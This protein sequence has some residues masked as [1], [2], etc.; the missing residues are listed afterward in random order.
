VSESRRAMEW[1]ARSVEWAAAA[2]AVPISL[3]AIC[4]AINLE[5]E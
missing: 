3:I 1:A 4:N 2:A 5:E